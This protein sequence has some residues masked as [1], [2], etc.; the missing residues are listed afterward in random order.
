MIRDVCQNHL[1]QALTLLTM[2]R[3]S[4]L[5]DEGI[6]DAK[7]AVLKAMPPIKKEDVILGQYTSSKTDPKKKVRLIL[8]SSRPSSNESLN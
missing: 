6:R 7:V 1:L 3:P 4:S 5:H 2:E 8:V